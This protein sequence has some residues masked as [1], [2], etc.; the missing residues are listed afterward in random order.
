[1]SSKRASGESDSCQ[2]DCRRRLRRRRLTFG[3][4]H[5]VAA[6]IAVSLVLAWVARE[7]RQSQREAARI[8]QMDSHPNWRWAGFEL[9]GVLDLDGKPS[10]E[11]PMWRRWV[12]IALGPRVRAINLE[13]TDVVDL[14]PIT[15][16]Q[17]LQDLN[18]RDTHVSELRPLAKLS[19]IRFLDARGTRVIDL[20]PLSKMD[21][22]EHLDVA[23]TAVSDLTP[24]SELKNLKELCLVATQ[25]TDVK[26]LGGLCN[27]EEVLLNETQ[28]SDVAPMAGLKNLKMVDLSGTQVRD[29]TP[30]SELMS[31]NNLDL[32]LSWRQNT[33]R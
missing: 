2:A 27:L 10:D 9:A 12:G 17:S 11:Q 1:M 7:Q 30:L 18:L 4:R 31:Q 25:V 28:V 24:I 20:S 6:F 22:L 16:F 33:H 13:A 3:L 26:A 29:V 21:T 14:E 19:R 8:L 32:G 15:E 23:H 5:L